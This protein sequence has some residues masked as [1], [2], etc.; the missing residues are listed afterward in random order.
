MRKLRKCY[1]QLFH[2]NCF[3]FN[4][5]TESYDEYKSKNLGEEST[6]SYEESLKDIHKKNLRNIVIGQ[7]NINSLRNKFDLLA[8]KSQR[9]HHC[10]SYFRN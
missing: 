1:L 5:F 9:D 10:V 4:C 7:L 2:R 8:E 6:D 3:I